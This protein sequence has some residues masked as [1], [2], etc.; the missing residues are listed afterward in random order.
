[1]KEELRELHERALNLLRAHRQG[2][3]TNEEIKKALELISLECE[4]RFQR[5]LSQ[6]LCKL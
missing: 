6:T 1:M 5:S 2:F 4:I 3:L